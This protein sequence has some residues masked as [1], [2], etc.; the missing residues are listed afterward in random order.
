M[1]EF[2]SKKLAY[3]FHILDLN[4]NGY[5]QLEDFSEMAEKVREIMQYE[6][7]SK[8]HK[9]ISDKATRFFHTLVKDINPADAHQIS[10][11]EWITFF[12]NEVVGDEDELD[13]YKEMVFNFMFDFFDQNRDGFISRK[14]YEDF[15][16]IFGIDENYLDKA[17]QKLDNSN[18]YKLS[19]YDLMSAVEDFL[20]AK[21]ESLPGN[22]VFGHW[23]SNPHK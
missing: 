20:S 13:N 9:R 16:S 10:E 12:E 5:V 7:G 2:Q 14:E 23:E 8:E 3:F 15:Y 21:D 1:S 11:K 22:W 4:R 6:E 19:R 18:A 17:F